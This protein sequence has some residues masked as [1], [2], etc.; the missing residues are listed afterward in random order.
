M[1]LA[2]T[3]NLTAG[4]FSLR[5]NEPLSLACHPAR[6]RAFGAACFA[7]ECELVLGGGGRA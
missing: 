4:S 6:A 7:C 3:G 2:F 5:E 1:S